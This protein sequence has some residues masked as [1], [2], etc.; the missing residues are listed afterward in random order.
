MKRSELVERALR[1]FVFADCRLGS[2]PSVR[3]TTL[4]RQVDDVQIGESSV[5]RT[6][7]QPVK[8]SLDSTGVVGS[9]FGKPYGA[10]LY[11]PSPTG[12]P[13][14]TIEGRLLGGGFRSQLSVP[15]FE[16]RNIV[17]VL[18]FDSPVVGF[19]GDRHV[20]SANLLCVL[21]VYLRAAASGET[22]AASRA[23]GEALKQVRQG[24]DLTQE[25]LAAAVGTSRIAVSRAESGAQPPS[26]SLL[27]AWCM[28][29]GLLAEI[30]ATRVEVVDITP[31]LLEA[32]RR[33]PHELERLSPAEYELFIAGRL[34]EMGYDVKQTGSTFQRDGG[35]DLIA[36]PKI[37]TVGAFLLAVQV[38][39][40]RGGTLTTRP[41]VDRLLAW[42]D[43][44]FRAALLATN[45]GFTADAKWVSELPQN[46]AF[47]R[48]RGFE[49]MKRWLQRNF[50]SGL[51]WR[52][53]PPSIE[54][55]PGIH[56]SIPK[57]AMHSV[58]RMAARAQEGHLNL[59]AFLASVAFF[60]DKRTYLPG[61]QA[62]KWQRDYY[63]HNREMIQR[64]RAQRRRR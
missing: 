51:D 55:A 26:P 39:H 58:G 21:L 62:K 35:I 63:E 44:D 25:E 48:T 30:D 64:Q 12:E 32:L 49:D 29:L 52:E 43:S 42:K 33:D 4:W 50:A 6:K 61:H 47:L 31:R 28:A 7:N 60:V 8:V 14:D 46:R 59:G 56:V 53:I 54:L 15:L 40:H 24:R 22:K 57:P 10:Y 34:D 38:K 1:D 5:A 45:T 19:F 3:A 2:H 18:S 9:A 27:H 23:L 36:V 11:E 37:R 16:G 20:G 41:E 17:G 13:N